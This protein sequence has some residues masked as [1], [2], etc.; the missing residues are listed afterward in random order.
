MHGED[1]GNE[2]LILCSTAISASNLFYVPE[3]EKSPL[4]LGIVFA[5]HLIPPSKIHPQ[6]TP[7]VDEYV[8]RPVY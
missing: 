1:P 7:V 6:S 4:Q 2:Q 3:K 5:V 8:R